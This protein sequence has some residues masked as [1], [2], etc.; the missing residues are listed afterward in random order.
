[1]CGPGGCSSG[2]LFYDDFSTSPTQPGPWTV[3]SGTWTW[4]SSSEM[5]DNTDVVEGAETWIGSRSWTNYTV[6]VQMQ[7][8]AQGYDS[9]VMFR[10]GQ[11]SPVNNH[12]AFYYF[13]IAGYFA[14]LGYTNGIWNG[15]APVVTYFPTVGQL[16]TVQIRVY[17]NRIRVSV[18]GQQLFDVT[19]A[20][21][22]MGSIGLRTFKQQTHYASV[23]VC[24]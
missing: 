3:V 13:G 5:F 4:D 1:M 18:D 7:I 23:L 19:S 21:E 14:T 15:L 11:T 9:G 10:V 24:P 12:G 20:A 16:Y 2:E 6:Q 17:G 22:P 8:A